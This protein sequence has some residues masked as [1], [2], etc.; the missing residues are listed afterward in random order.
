VE[1]C[2]EQIEGRARDQGAPPRPRERIDWTQ[3]SIAR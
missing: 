1:V 2:I 3:I